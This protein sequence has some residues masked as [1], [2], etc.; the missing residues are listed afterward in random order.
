MKAGTK[1]M[2]TKNNCFGI[3]CKVGDVFTYTTTG[4]GKRDIDDSYWGLPSTE[5]RFAYHGFKLYKKMIIIVK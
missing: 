5:E 4:H 1:I 2:A 3:P